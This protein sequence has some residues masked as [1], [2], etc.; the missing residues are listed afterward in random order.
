[1]MI[2]NNGLTTAKATSSSSSF[3][4]KG[5]I[6]G[7]WQYMQDASEY[8]NTTTRKQKTNTACEEEKRKRSSSKAVFFVVLLL[9]WCELLFDFFQD[10]QGVVV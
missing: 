2:A 6:I 5:T 9:A 7:K 1:M 4:V 3:L 10:E 8:K